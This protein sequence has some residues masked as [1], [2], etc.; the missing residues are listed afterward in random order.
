MR[1][2]LSA[3]LVAAGLV[4]S[5]SAGVSSD[6]VGFSDFGEW[7]SA[8]NLP[9][10]DV[11]DASLFDSSLSTLL[12]TE[13]FDSLAT[14]SFGSVSNGT[15][16]NWWSWTAYSAAGNMNVGDN[17]AGR[18]IASAASGAAMTIVFN[19]ETSSDGSFVSGLRGIGGGFRFYDAA[20]NAINGRLRL[21]LSDGA[22]VVRNFGSDEAFAGF[23]LT[24]PDLTIASLTIEPFGSYAGT[25]FVGAHT[26][27]LGYAGVAIPAPGAIALL[28]AAGLIG[29]VR[30]RA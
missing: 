17:A 13:D 22:S 11:P 14:G 16:A 10:G 12:R 19:G 4:G 8:G 27:Y 23:W 6:A 15:A 5:A 18:F 25:R 21:T 3:V 20:G 7:L 30:R 2:T 26:L 1:S 9:G 28:G 24:A 29:T